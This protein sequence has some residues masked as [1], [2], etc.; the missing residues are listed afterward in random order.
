MSPATLRLQA[1]NI[2]MLDSIP[3]MRPTAESVD[4]TAWSFAGAIV[5]A[6]ND[7]QPW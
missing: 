4:E 2:M 6:D 7:L 5:L 3:L 1:R